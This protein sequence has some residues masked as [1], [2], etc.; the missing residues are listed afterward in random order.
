MPF[1]FSTLFPPY[2]L[3]V[4]ERYIHET[5]QDFNRVREQRLKDYKKIFTLLDLEDHARDR[6]N[7]VFAFFSKSITKDNSFQTDEVRMISP[8]KNFWIALHL[9]CVP[10]RLTAKVYKVSQELLS[11]LDECREDLELVINWSDLCL[12]ANEQSFAEAHRIKLQDFIDYLSSGLGGVVQSINS[13]NS[14]LEKRAQTLQMLFSTKDVRE[15]HLEGWLRVHRDLLVHSE[16]NC[17]LVCAKTWEKVRRA[18]CA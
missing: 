16:T 12:P 13:I 8:F 11:V 18:C 2:S 5:M 10:A 1:S 3:A 6:R 7:K 17:Y 4:Y 15:E 9:T 14:Q